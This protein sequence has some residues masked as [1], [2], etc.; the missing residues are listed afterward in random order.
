MRNIEV[1]QLDYDLTPE[2][3]L[4]LVDRLG[5]DLAGVGIEHGAGNDAAHHLVLGH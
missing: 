3:G 5:D 2:D 4:A 1:E